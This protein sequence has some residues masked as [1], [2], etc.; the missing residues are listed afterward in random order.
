MHADLLPVLAASNPA[1]GIAL[2]TG[3][4]VELASTSLHQSA[5][6]ISDM[7]QSKPVS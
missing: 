4:Q 6:H 7:E 3:L 5:H 2:S 1:Q